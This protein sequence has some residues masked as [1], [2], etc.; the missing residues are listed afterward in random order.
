MNT[1]PISMSLRKAMY[2]GQLN[3]AASSLAGAV[4]PLH[5]ITPRMASKQLTRLSSTT[6]RPA[7]TLTLDSR[8]QSKAASPSPIALRAKSTSAPTNNEVKLD[9]DSFF[10]LRASRRRYSLVSS[11]ASSAISTS[12]GVQ[13]LSGQDLEHL[14]ATVM[15]LDPFV[16]LGLATATCG[17][18]GWLLGPA[19]GNGIWG[20]VYSKYKPSVNT[21]E[22]EFFDRIRRF[23][24]DP[25]TNS[26]S[27][28]VPDYYGEKIGSVAGYRNW[29][30]DQRAYNRKR[31][32]FIA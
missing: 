31:R 6:A 12:I 23:R 14:G 1:N 28:P 7:A 8:P 11:V 9:W 10:K 21:K 4:R 29:L 18:V 30:K 25:S 13:V 16:V 32:N 22:K 20:L 26:I 27:N 5:Q 3:P 15:G 2:L 17:A 19:L 24:V